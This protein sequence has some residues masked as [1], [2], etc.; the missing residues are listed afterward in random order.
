[1]R[2]YAVCGTDMRRAHAMCGTE[3]HCAYAPS[4]TEIRRAYAMSGTELGSRAGRR[5]RRACTTTTAAKRCTHSELTLR[6]TWLSS[7]RAAASGTSAR[8]DQSHNP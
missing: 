2:A 3:I 8:P 4:G 5:L 7:S 6:S 1:M